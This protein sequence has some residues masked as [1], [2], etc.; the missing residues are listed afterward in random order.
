[1]LDTLKGFLELFKE[2]GAATVMMVW[3]ALLY[4]RANKKI[5]KIQDA[6]L[7]DSKEAL[8]ALIAAKHV[9]DELENHVEEISEQS[10]KN[11]EAIREQD[12]HD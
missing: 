7:V 2:Y 3:F 5:E 10:K 6:R 11:Y 9:L 1:M 8:S 4:F 12:R